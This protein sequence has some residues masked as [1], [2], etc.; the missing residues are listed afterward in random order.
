M[1]AYPQAD[2]KIGGYTDNTGDKKANVKLSDDRA[3]DVMAELVKR[4]IDAK[5]LAAE[6]YGDQYPVASN[7]T[8]EG[9]AKN[10]RVSARVTKK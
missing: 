8:E 5:R 7:D 9:K 3:K 2:L 1:K 6:G 4:G 10:R